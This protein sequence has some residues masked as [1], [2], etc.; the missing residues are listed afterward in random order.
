MTAGMVGFGA[1]LWTRHRL[2]A[3]DSAVADAPAG[4]ARFASRSLLLITAIS[5]VI[6]AVI[7]GAYLRSGKPLA[8][9]SVAMPLAG[10]SWLAAVGWKL[11]QLDETTAEG[12]AQADRAS[13]RPA[14]R[15]SVAPPRPSPDKSPSDR[16]VSL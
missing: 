2:L 7:V 6:V 10:L 15:D 3:R 4:K 9:L 8:W 16:H 14:K 1:L 13:R 5:T 12:A 11:R